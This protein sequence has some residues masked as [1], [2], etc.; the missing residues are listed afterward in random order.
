MV[1]VMLCLPDA[2]TV[3]FKFEDVNTAN[4]MLESAQVQIWHKM[5]TSHRFQ[6]TSDEIQWEAMK[7]KFLKSRLGVLLCLS[8][9]NTVTFK[10]ED[11]NTVN[12][13]LESAPIQIW[14]NMLT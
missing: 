7:P 8:D 6:S 1:R 11:V 10:F 9:V 3:N 13:M 2:N 5:L 12:R 4:R 14:H